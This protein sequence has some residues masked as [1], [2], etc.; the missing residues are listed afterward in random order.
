M[1]EMHFGSDF[2]TPKPAHSGAG[3]QED[4]LC[5]KSLTSLQLAFE[6]LKPNSYSIASL[7]PLVLR[8]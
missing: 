4:D 7:A 2:Y 1:D 6:K 5:L 3:L 8:L